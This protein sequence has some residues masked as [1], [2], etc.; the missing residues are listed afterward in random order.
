MLDLVRLAAVRIGHEDLRIPPYHR[1]ALIY[2]L[3][4]PQP[5]LRQ[6][7]VLPETFSLLDISRD[8]Y[9]HNYRHIFPFA[10]TIV[11]KIAALP[12]TA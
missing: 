8:S 2:T 9:R 12:H 6:L 4:G 5:Q 3:C 1:Y 7:K 11:L 10:L